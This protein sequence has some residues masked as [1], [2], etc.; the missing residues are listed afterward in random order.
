MAYSLAEI[1]ATAIGIY[2]AVGLLVGIA[3]AFVGAKKI[4]PNA[5][6]GSIGFRL[7]IIPGAILLWPL[8]LKRWLGGQTSPP[9]EQTAH[10]LAAGGQ[11]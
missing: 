11:S 5:A 4:D 10:D 2:L 1:F 3:F 7:I 6:D 8:V 9:V